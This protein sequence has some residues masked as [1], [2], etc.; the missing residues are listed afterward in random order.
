MG[1]LLRGAAAIVA[2]SPKSNVG[3]LSRVEIDT[4]LLPTLCMC[5]IMCFGLMNPIAFSRASQESV[6]LAGSALFTLSAGN[7]L[8]IVV[9]AVETFCCSTTGGS[10]SIDILSALVVGVFSF[11]SS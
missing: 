10:G 3:F 9:E 6:N 2:V 1:I 8:G 7:V 5:F 4:D 11:E